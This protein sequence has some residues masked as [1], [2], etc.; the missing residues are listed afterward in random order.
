MKGVPEEELVQRPLS[1]SGRRGTAVL[2]GHTSSCTM[3][4]KLALLSIHANKGVPEEELVQGPNLLLRWQQHHDSVGP[5]EQL[6]Q[7]LVQTA[8]SKPSRASLQ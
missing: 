8:T 3:R 6:D 1:C 5:D 7:R 2:L 4:D